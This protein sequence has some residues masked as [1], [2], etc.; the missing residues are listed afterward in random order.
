M[1]HVPRETHGMCRQGVKP[2]ER[3]RSVSTNA[4]ER[5]D[6]APL[7]PWHHC[8]KH[9]RHCS[10][11]DPVKVRLVQGFCIGRLHSGRPFGSEYIEV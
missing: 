9:E 4:V 8:Q 3:G 2:T 6:F 5:H 1:A 10:R 11:E 7:W